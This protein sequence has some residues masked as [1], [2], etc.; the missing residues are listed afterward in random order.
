MFDN[1]DRLQCFPW[2]GGIDAVHETDADLQV[3]DP[4]NGRGIFM[5][6]CYHVTGTKVQI[7]TNEV[8]YICNDKGDTVDVI[9]APFER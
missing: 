4:S 2:E 8:A 1:L 5:L 3:I 7:L 6:A 9:R